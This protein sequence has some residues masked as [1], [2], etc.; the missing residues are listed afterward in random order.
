MRVGGGLGRA[1]GVGVWYGAGGRGDISI[2]K[3]DNTISSVACAGDSKNTVGEIMWI[4]RKTRDRSNY[5][6]YYQVRG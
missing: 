4:S 5:G 1:S 3:F 6:R 2:Y